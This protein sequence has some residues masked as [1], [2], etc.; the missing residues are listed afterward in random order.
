[1]WSTCKSFLGP[2][3]PSNISE[4][5][6]SSN[7][8][9]SHFCPAFSHVVDQELSKQRRAVDCLDNMIGRMGKGRLKL[10]E[11]ST[12]A[13]GGH[14]VG[15]D[16]R[17]R[18]GSCGWERGYWGHGKG[19]QPHQRQA[20]F[21]PESTQRGSATALNSRSLVSTEVIWNLL[22]SRSYVPRFKWAQCQCLQPC[23][24]EIIHLP[25]GWVI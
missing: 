21:S 2:S 4:L 12:W 7:T 5:I 23:S 13:P 9:S 25:Q 6:H 17:Q 16:W 19:H 24:S 22:D 15:R 20:L 1:M 10:R 18:L 8:D 3:F 14:N 11:A